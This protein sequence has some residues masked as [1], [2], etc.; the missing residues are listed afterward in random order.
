L[1]R[2]NTHRGRVNTHLGGVNTHLRRAPRGWV[3]RRAPRR[4]RHHH[5]LGFLS[6]HLWP[7]TKK[8]VSDGVP[9]PP[10]AALPVPPPPTLCFP[11]TSSRGGRTRVQRHGTSVPVWVAS[12]SSPGDNEPNPNAPRP[13]GAS[14][15]L[16]LRLVRAK[17]RGADTPHPPPYTRKGGDRHTR[18]GWRA[19]SNL[20]AAAVSRRA[21]HAR[22]ARGNAGA[23]PESTCLMSAR[24][25]GR[26]CG[27]CGR[28]RDGTRGVRL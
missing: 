13:G 2:V 18:R 3:G 10:E 26:R 17:L 6:P 4:L 28:R 7:A 16:G 27:W 1:S 21:H 19:R 8:G 5:V 22:G 23:S 9:P 20:F 14:A 11:T 25:L 15:W 12:S 24:A